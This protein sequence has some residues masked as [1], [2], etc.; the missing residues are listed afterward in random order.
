[1]NL[2]HFL[3]QLLAY[4]LGL[5]NTMKYFYFAIGI[6]TL[7]IFSSRLFAQE[8]TIDYPDFADLS[9]WQLNGVPLAHSVENRYNEHV[10]R[11]TGPSTHHYGSAF[12]KD[13]IPLEDERG[14]RGAFSAF[15]S[16]R[17]G[18]GQ[19]VAGAD[20]ITFTIQTVANNIG[21]DGGGLGYFNIPRS[22]AIEFD[23]WTNEEYGD[24]DASHIG[25][26]TG[27]SIVSIVTRTIDPPMDNYQLL[28]AWVDY[29]GDT[30]LLE[31]RL[32]QTAQ[33]PDTAT[34]S[35]VID[36]PKIIQTK[37]AYIGFTAATGAAWNSHFQIHK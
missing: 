30:K 37:N 9:K 29:N 14:F 12:L 4:I 21:S 36:I 31:L 27:G 15:F 34:V 33:R 10:L 25:I 26:D 13:P 35:S 18:D 19:N 1:M 3:S 7:T 2:F 28:Y 17:I 11:L 8:I 23:T 32:S 22:V 5:R 6:I 20:G 24:I 16:F